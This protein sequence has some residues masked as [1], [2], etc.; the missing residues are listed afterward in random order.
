MPKVSAL[1]NS[2][3]AKAPQ[4]NKFDLTH[5]RKFTLPMGFLIPIMC[6]PLLPGD[7][8]RVNH[9]VMM[10]MAPMLA[11]VMARVDVII[12]SFVVP[13]RLVWQDSEKFFT[14][15][16][17]G[18]ETPVFPKINFK[19]N[20]DSP[21]IWPRTAPGS[22]ADYMGIP[23]LN[24]PASDLLVSALEFRAYALIHDNFY[25]DENLSD[26][27]DPSLASGTVSDAEAIKLLTLRSRCW[28][29]DY[30]TSCL[31]FA[32]RGPS[33]KIPMEGLADITYKETSEIK[34]TDGSPAA[35]GNLASASGGQLIADG[36]GQ[37][38]IENIDEIEFQNATVTVNDLTKAQKLQ[39]WM[40]LM[41]RAGARYV[42][43]LKAIWLTK[44]KDASLQRPQY[45]GG[46][47]F[48]MVI[49]EVLSTV[50]VDG[51]NPQGNM[52][53]HGFGH[54]NNSGFVY[55]ADEHCIVIS[56]MSVLPRTGYTQGLSRDWQKFDKFDWP[57]PQ[58]AHIGEQEVKNNEIWVNKA[59]P[60]A[61]QQSETFGYQSRYAEYKYC[62]STTHGGL[63]TDSYSFWTMDRIFD[64]APVLNEDFVKADPTTRIFAVPTA[65]TNLYCQLINRVDALRPLPFYGTPI[66]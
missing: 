48:P 16:K 5:E 7:K 28:E 53:G 59:D 3:L 41:A 39:E 64:A 2:I 56:L 35:D 46:G 55:E 43:Q 27:I 44:P 49:S 62:P 34:A 63:K 22:L 47:K 14:G 18:D 54:G 9:Q 42:E 19:K 51:G 66:H 61:A 23:E 29:K 60:G 24:A 1:F 33:V 37:A 20:V 25:R 11:P 8:W 6:K 45:L 10:R 40:E 13:I 30:F 52:S 31:P 15:G 50:D 4:R 38:R 57:W 58:F 32:Q 12:E 21:D 65:E 26:P 36:T 17:N